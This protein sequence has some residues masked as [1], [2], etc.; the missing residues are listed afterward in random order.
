MESFGAFLFFATSGV[1]MLVIAPISPAIA[2]AFIFLQ[3]ISV[4]A[5]LS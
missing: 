2:T 3:V 4:A 1:G 5:M